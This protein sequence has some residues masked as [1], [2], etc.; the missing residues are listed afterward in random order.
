[1]KQT[2]ASGLIMKTL[3]PGKDGHTLLLDV[4]R[5]NNR[6]LDEI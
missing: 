3:V 6:A 5:N 1:M 4:L 2:N